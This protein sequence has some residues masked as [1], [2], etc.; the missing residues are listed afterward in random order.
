MKK[1]DMISD[2]SEQTAKEVV[3]NEESWRG[4]LNTA[5]RLY[6]YPFKD[7]L[8]IYAQR[9]DAQACASIEVWNEKMHCWVNK[10]AKGI[11]L[12][13]DEN[14]KKLRYVFDISD[15]HKARRIG[16]FPHLWEMGEEHKE[17]VLSH[18]EKT[19]GETDREAGFAGRI[20]NIADR[21]AE[22]CYKEIAEGMEYLKENKCLAFNIYDKLL[23]F[24]VHDIV[25]HEVCWRDIEQTVADAVLLLL[26]DDRK[27][28]ALEWLR[29][30]RLRDIWKLQ[31]DEED[32][33]LIIDHIVVNDDG[34]AEVHMI[35][36]SIQKYT[37][38]KFRPAQHMA[39]K[40]KE[41]TRKKK[42][43][44]KTNPKTPTIVTKCENCGGSVQQYTGQKLRRFCCNKCRNQWWNQHLDQV[45]RKAYYEIACQ[46]CG[47]VITVYGDS[48]RKYCSHECYIADRFEKK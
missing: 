9:P 39:E 19:Y 8:L 48:R 3:R 1:Y 24:A 33:A 11:A 6:K 32:I 45:N 28:K 25:M 14:Y 44:K 42:S 35:D 5:S 27:K 31:S 10:G 37:F 41:Q 22:D 20:R 43:E 18:L 2:L 17:A 46:H 30:F 47:K 7:Q 38:P 16:R 21:I 40:Q 4:Y 34:M 15:V 29:D 26:P 23:H 13:D 36:D 12:I